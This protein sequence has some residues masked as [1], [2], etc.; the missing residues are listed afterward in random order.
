MN[1]KP[2]YISKEGFEKMTVELEY[3][4]TA[5][6]RE[7]AD[8]IEKA[9]DLGDLKENADYHDA[10]DELGRVESR[11]YELSDAIKRAVIIEAKQT[12]MVAIGSK[13][14]VV[15][16]GKEKEFAVVGSREA[17]PIEGRISNESP[18]GLVLLGKKVGDIAEVKAPSGII[19]YTIKEIR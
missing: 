10:K 4:K 3:L 18:L 6:R 2:A 8:R 15:F 1:D 5:K 7:V 17:D 9:K 14:L 11:I 16:N 13:V 12:D 19:S